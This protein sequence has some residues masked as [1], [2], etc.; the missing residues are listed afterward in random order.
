[1]RLVPHRTVTPARQ[2]EQRV[3][4]AMHVLFMTLWALL[5]QQQPP[6]AA[7]TLADPLAAVEARI[8]TLTHETINP[9]LSC[10]RGTV[11]NATEWLCVQRSSNAADAPSVDTNG[12]SGSR[13]RR[14]AGGASPRA[15]RRR[16]ALIGPHDRYNFGDLLFE[17]VVTHLL[18]HRAQ[19]LP[20]ELVSVGMVTNNMSV[21]GGNPRVVSMKTMSEQ[22]KDEAA[23]PFGPYDMIFLGGEAGDCDY[24]CGGPMMQ[25]PELQARAEREKTGYDCAYFMPKR[26]LVPVG[27]PGRPGDTPAHPISAL[28]SVGGLSL[29]DTPCKRAMMEA[30]Y[31]SCRDGRLTD[32]LPGGEV[33]T[34]PDSAVMVNALFESIITKFA[35]TGEVARVQAAMHNRYLAFQMSASMTKDTTASIAVALTRIANDHNLGIVFFCAGTAPGHDSNAEYEQVRRLLPREIQTHILQHQ[36][37]W[38]NVAVVSRATAVLASSLHVRIMAFIHGRPR[39][40]IV[41]CGRVRTAAGECTEANPGLTSCPRSGAKHGDFIR[42]WEGAS[43]LGVNNSMGVLSPKCTGDLAKDVGAAIAMTGSVI[44]HLK[45]RVKICQLLYA[46]SFDKLASMLNK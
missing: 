35:E 36:N 39:V 20:A 4:T 8:A 30:D 31:K 29:S 28:N 33:K 23:G 7:T 24:D 41:R 1:M 16:V 9:A 21:F 34:T 40:T 2:G 13:P 6:A 14:A 19:Y 44:G 12:T 11:W 10:G 45:R 46:K 42:L 43:D 27:W 18:V 25:T 3:L 22:S 38:A 26:M 15:P 32:A 37:V 5:M 17:K